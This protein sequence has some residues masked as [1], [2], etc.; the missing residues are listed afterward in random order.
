M[1][2]VR[3]PKVVSIARAPDCEHC[4]EPISLQNGDAFHCATSKALIDE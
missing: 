4:W 3:R 1:D 2:P